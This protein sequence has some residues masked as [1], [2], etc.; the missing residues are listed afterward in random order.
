MVVQVDDVPCLSQAFS[1]CRGR[2]VATS[3][4]T[5]AISEQHLVRSGFGPDEEASSGDP[6]PRPRRR[7]T[8][9]DQVADTLANCTVW[10]I[11]HDAV[12]PRTVGT[13]GLGRLL[14]LHPCSTVARLRPGG[15]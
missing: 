8:L 3:R 5:E 9:M 2:S 1:M 11:G 14:H 13:G 12:L 4:N 6:H 7:P 15:R 10:S